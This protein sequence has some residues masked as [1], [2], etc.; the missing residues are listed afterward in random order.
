MCDTFVFFPDTNRTDRVVQHNM[1]QFV[2]S[3]ENK[4]IY[5]IRA[6]VVLHTDYFFLPFFFRVCQPDITSVQPQSQL[7]YPSLVEV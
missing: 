4:M 1:R 6:A 5:Q 2:T 3:S 7:I